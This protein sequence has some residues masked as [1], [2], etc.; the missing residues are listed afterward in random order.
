[1]STP[2]DPAGAIE[3][4][5]DEVPFR[6]DTAEERAAREAAEADKAETAKWEKMAARQLAGEKAAADAEAERPM[7]PLLAFLRTEGPALFGKGA[8]GAADAPEKTKPGKLVV[9]GADD[10]AQRVFPPRK[11]L[12][13]PFIEEKNLGMVYARRG[14]GKTLFG[15]REKR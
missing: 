12:L 15:R 9:V 1:M 8:A 14:T 10:F 2:D 5:T 7:A 3:T 6:T 13:S 11:M 4:P